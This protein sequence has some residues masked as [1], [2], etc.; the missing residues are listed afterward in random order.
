[1]EPE[2]QMEMYNDVY[3]IMFTDKSDTDDTVR[4]ILIYSDIADIQLIRYMTQ[5]MMHLL[6]HVLIHMCVLRRLGLHGASKAGY[7][8]MERYGT[9]IGGLDMIRV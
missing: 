2:Q 7:P 1:M 9:S 8:D 6:I 4:Q 5:L 3:Y